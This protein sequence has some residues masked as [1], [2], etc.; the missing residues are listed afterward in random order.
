MATSDVLVGK[1]VTLVVG[2]GRLDGC[3]AREGQKQTGSIPGRQAEQ[4]RVRDRQPQK[5][6]GYCALC[7]IRVVFL[8][9]IF[10]V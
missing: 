3:P 6:E 7:D 10:V 1:A 2:G 9:P 8:A 5:R 4:G